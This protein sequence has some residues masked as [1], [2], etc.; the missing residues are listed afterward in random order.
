M[1]KKSR[2]LLAAALASFLF[3]IFIALSYEWRYYALAVDVV[4]LVFLIWFSLEIKRSTPFW[5]KITTVVLP[6][7]FFIGY[8]LFTAII[9][10]KVIIGLCLSL[11]LGIFIYV[12]FLVENVFLF[13]VERKTVPLYRAAYTVGSVLMLL[14]AFFLF[15]S[16]FSF[17]LSCWWNLVM[18]FFITLFLF[19]YHFFSVMIELPEDEWQLKNIGPYVII[20]S[21]GIAQ[22]AL[23]ISFWPI[24]IFK[25]S[26]YLTALI[27]I[28]AGLLQADLR[29]RLFERTWLT[30]L[31]IGIAVILGIILMTEWR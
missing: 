19:I 2:F 22:M 11:F 27:Y 9:P 13:A 30:F 25:G 15:D 7:A 3:F 24:G 18:A 21:L 8:G 5:L 10:Y 14:T 16:L 4:I 31:W 17:N 29:G 1:S 23:V 26:I 12:I 20:P 6:V 28:I